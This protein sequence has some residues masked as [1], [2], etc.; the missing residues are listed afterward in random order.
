MWKNLTN[1]QTWNFS[2]NSICL[3]SSLI[4]FL[5]LPMRHETN[6]RF[7]PW[8]STHRLNN[9]RHV[10]PTKGELNFVVDEGLPRVAAQRCYTVTSQN[11]M[12]LPP[13]VVVE[14]SDAWSAVLAYTR[15]FASFFTVFFV[16]AW[17]ETA[18]H[19]CQNRRNLNVE[20]SRMFLLG[21]SAIFVCLIVAFKGLNSV[22][23]G[24]FRKI[25]VE[26]D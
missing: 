26:F 3:N 16:I 20:L 22:H 4:F 18:R 1:F 9:T 13:P 23:T 5:M 19:W 10:T 24:Y 12:F 21:K 25:H 7:V 17:G 11:K 8:V 15:S 2:K 14:V 6:G